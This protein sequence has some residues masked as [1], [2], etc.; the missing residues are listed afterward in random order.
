MKRIILAG[1][2]LEISEIG[3]GGIPIIPLPKNEAVSVVRHC[4]DLGITFFD[5]ANMYQTS[6]EKIGAALGTVRDKV[7]IAT[8]TASR[9]AKE[10]A[11]HIDLSLQQLKTDWIDLYQLHNVS[12]QEA[13]QQVLAPKGAYEAARKARDAGKIRHIGISSHS[14]PTALEALKTGLFQTL[15]FP[16]NFIEH[17]PADELFPFARRHNIGLIGMKPLGGGMLERADLC[18]GFLQQHPYIAPIPGIRAKKE[19]DEIIALYANPKPLA[20]AQLKE[21]ASIQSVLGEKFCHR[22]EYCMPCEQGVQINSVLIFKAAAKRLTQEAVKAW[23]RTAM[24]TVEKCIECGE[25]EAKCPYNLP[26][27]DLLKEN[28][29]LFRE[30]SEFRFE[31][32]FFQSWWEAYR[33]SPQFLPSWEI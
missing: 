18:F 25:C 24:E 14:I 20:E 5:T 6:E 16:F 19:A 17:D 30:F 33:R 8:K 23:L 11:G 1:T 22:C 12:N 32:E 28:L 9:D 27:T 26:I 31:L 29:A 7:V 2:D 13:L 15:Q 3:F 4:Y 21:M 10:A